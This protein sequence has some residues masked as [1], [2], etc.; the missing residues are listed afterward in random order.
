MSEV[1]FSKCAGKMSLTGGES[2]AFSPGFGDTEI[3]SG[4]CS[5]FERP[6]SVLSS[7]SLLH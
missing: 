1:D 3:E 5:K 7:F 4:I 6:T 2:C